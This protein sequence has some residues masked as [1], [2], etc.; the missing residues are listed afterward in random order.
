[1]KKCKVCRKEF[2][3][4]YSSVQMVCSPK[5]A[6]EYTK[7]K[8]KNKQVLDKA[9]KERNDEKRLKTA[10]KTTE[11][12]VHKYIRERDKGKPCISCGKPWQPTF[13]AG[14]LFSRKQ[15]G[16]LKYHLDNIHGQC[17]YCNLRLEGNVTEYTLRLP[18][19]IGSDRFDK[20]IKLAR[21]EKKYVK[22]WTLYELEEIRKN[23]PKL[24]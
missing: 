18:E 13:Q 3:P 15:Y 8:K 16:G 23:L 20:L 24:L 2:K 14:H 4:T 7:Q 17:E 19:R 21:L 22:K 10:L 9:K 11:L 5:C 6:I 1:M 12:A